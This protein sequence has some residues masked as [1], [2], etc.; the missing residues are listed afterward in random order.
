[1]TIS[2]SRRTLLHGVTTLNSTAQ[3]KG[4]EIM[5][6]LRCKDPPTLKHQTIK[7]YRDME[8]HVL[9]LDNGWR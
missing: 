5:F 4:A 9:N 3:I 7:L 2:F 1:M 6:G 8:T